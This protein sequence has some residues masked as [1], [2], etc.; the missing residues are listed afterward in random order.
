MTDIDSTNLPV[1][2]YR[3]RFDPGRWREDGFSSLDESLYWSNRS[4]GIACARMVIGYFNGHAPLMSELLHQALRVSAYSPMGWIHK[5][6][7]KILGYYG[8]SGEARRIGDDLEPIV[9]ALIK[10]ELIIASVTERF[11]CDGRKGGHLVVVRGVGLENGR[12]KV[13]HFN[14]P[15]SWGQD[16]SSVS[17]ERFLCSFANRAIV[18]RRGP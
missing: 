13:I 5:D 9:E 12:V 14:D 18:V 3:Q 10:S 7:L 6:L 16:N 17:Y 15:S 11:P 8:L 2:L 1:P 4:C